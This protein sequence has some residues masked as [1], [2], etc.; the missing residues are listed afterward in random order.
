[1]GYLAATARSTKGDPMSKP[2]ERPES[3]KYVRSIKDAVKRRYAKNYLAWLVA[4]KSGDM[5]ARGALSSILAKAVSTNL[6][7]LN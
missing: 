3:A 1:M 6:D 5:P 7:A 2:E 4:G